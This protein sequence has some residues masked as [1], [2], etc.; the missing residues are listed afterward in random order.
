MIMIVSSLQVDSVQEPLS[1][2]TI[3]RHANGSIGLQ[4]LKVA[5]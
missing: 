5:S 2:G 4:E 3:M 1:S